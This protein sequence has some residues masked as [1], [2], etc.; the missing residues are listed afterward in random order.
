ML[1]AIAFMIAAYGSARL[2]N[3]GLKRH[4]DNSN[5]TI[6]TWI[7]SIIGIFILL[8][9]ALIVNHDGTSLPSL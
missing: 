8:L 1:P 6:I 9:L 2:I 5:A 3:D 4:P 7:V